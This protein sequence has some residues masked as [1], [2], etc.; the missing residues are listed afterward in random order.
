MVGGVVYC[1]LRLSYAPA[2][3]AANGFERLEHSSVAG[4]PFAALLRELQAYRDEQV[5]RSRELEREVADARTVGMAIGFIIAEHQTSD[6]QATVLLT[7]L[8]RARGLSEHAMAVE[9]YTQHTGAPPHPAV[10]GRPRNQPGKDKLLAR[11][12]ARWSNR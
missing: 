7:E 10:P 2:V 6:T 5:T 1:W 3:T 4:L 11:R 12:T 8:A 9:I